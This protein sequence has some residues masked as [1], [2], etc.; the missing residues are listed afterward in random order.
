MSLTKRNLEGTFENAVN[1]NAL[2]V[3]VKIST[4]GSIADE[5]IINP[6]DNFNDKL[7]YYRKSYDEDLVLKTYSGIKIIGLTFGNSYDDIECDF[8]NI[9]E[10][11]L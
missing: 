5:V 10:G 4:R 6:R 8:E 1:T 9:P 7:N 3:G 11:G 2:F